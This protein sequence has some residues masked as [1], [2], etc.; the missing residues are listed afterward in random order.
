MNPINRGPLG[1]AFLIGR[2]PAAIPASSHEAP[3][4][5]PPIST[6]RTSFLSDELVRSL[7][8]VK[9]QAQFLLY[10]ADQI[11]DSL[12]QLVEEHDDCQNA[13]L[14][15]VLGMYS[16]QLESKHQGLGDKIAETCQEVY[17]TVREFDAA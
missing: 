1:S 3:P 11:E 16:A 12:H 4:E 5:D 6:P 8:E 17:V 10:L 9:G 7:S 14:C 15:R 13:F 2:E